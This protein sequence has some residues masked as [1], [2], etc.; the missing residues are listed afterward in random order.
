VWV[1]N[2]T[3]RECSFPFSIFHFPFSHSLV[4]L[5]FVAPT[6][7]VSVPRNEIQKKTNEKCQI[8]L[9]RCSLLPLLLPAC[10]FGFALA[11]T[12]GD[13]ASKIEE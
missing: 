12:F 2:P 1:R 5:P 10:S 3:A 7:F 13:T 8:T 6:I 4:N 9:G 11:S